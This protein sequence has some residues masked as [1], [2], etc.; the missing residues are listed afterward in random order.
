MKDAPS[1]YIP[2]TLLGKDML[3]YNLPP[4]FPKTCLL[5]LLSSIQR[6][7]FLERTG[8]SPSSW[9]KHPCSVSAHSEIH[10]AG[11][12]PTTLSQTKQVTHQLSRKPGKEFPSS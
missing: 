4:F 7:A 3:G 5:C 11:R 2:S 9:K 1:A 6:D 12:L 10:V 8:F